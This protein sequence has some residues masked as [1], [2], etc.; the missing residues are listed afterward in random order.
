M[1]FV[2]LCDLQFYS[3]SNIQSVFVAPSTENSGDNACSSYTV[4]KIKPEEGLYV[5]DGLGVSHVVLLCDHGALLVHHHH[6]VG[7][8]NSTAKQTVQTVETA[9]EGMAVIRI[10]RAGWI[11]QSSISVLWWLMNRIEK[12]QLSLTCRWSPLCR[13]P[14][15]TNRLPPRS[16]L[17]VC[18]NQNTN[19]LEIP[20]S[21]DLFAW[22]WSGNSETKPPCVSRRNTTKPK[23]LQRRL[24]ITAL[25]SGDS[26]FFIGFHSNL[27]DSFC[28]LTT[29][30]SHTRLGKRF[31]WK[32]PSFHKM[33]SP[34]SSVILRYIK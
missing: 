2:Q 23:C 22:R 29:Q 32:R 34:N 10:T 33:L 28:V 27:A 9:R 1:A 21:G 5:D 17:Q 24:K 31:S 7:E 8:S 6:G 19:G 16:L 13:T 14:W 30:K 25:H 11:N 12:L 3:R 20:T 18:T 26:A 4:N 15:G